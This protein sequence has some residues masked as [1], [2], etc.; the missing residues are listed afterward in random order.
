MV[1]GHNRDVEKIGV[2]DFIRP[3]WICCRGEYFTTSG[4][5]DSIALVQYR[6][7][8]G[9]RRTVGVGNPL[10]KYP[11]RRERPFEYLRCRAVEGF[12]YG[13]RSCNEMLVS[14]KN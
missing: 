3:E 7:R 2:V 13:I 9:V 5:G 12:R 10:H 14:R 11:C 1:D 8:T 4:E 6:F